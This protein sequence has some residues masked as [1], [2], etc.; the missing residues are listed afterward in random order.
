MK[1]LLLILILFISNIGNSQNKVDERDPIYQTEFSMDL[2]RKHSTIS[3]SKYKSPTITESKIIFNTETTSCD[4]SN[5]IELVLSTGETLHFENARIACVP[6][7]NSNFHL[8]GSLL[9]T[10]EL[11][12]K[13]SQIEILVIKLGTVKYPVVFKEKG[14]NLKVSEGNF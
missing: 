3:I 13:L 6:T 10:T 9:L 11:Y 2:I 7:E 14:E 4:N 1:N 12:D 5:G 8:Y